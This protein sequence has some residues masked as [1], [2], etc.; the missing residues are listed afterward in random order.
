MNR[1]T[2]VAKAIVEGEFDGDGMNEEI[3]DSVA[4]A[5]PGVEKEG[6]RQ[7]ERFGGKF[8]EGF[9]SRLEKMAPRISKALG[10]RMDGR[11]A[12]ATMGDEAG[13]SFV[14]RMA[15]KVRGAGDRI[16][17][18][19]GDR[20]ASR[21][22][23]IRRGVDRALDDDFADRVGER[24]ASRFVATLSAEI[25][26][27]E[28]VIGGAMARLVSGNR[29]RGGAKGG[30]DIGRLFG[31]GS[32]N[33]A[34]NLMGKTIGGTVR[35]TQ[36]LT[37]GLS[38][39]FGTFTK[40]ASQAAQGANMLQKGMAGLQAVG[41][42]AGA[43]LGKV[44]P[45]I[46]ASGPAAAVAIAAVLVVMSA[47]VSVAGALV[48]IVV[49]LSA[50]IVSGLVGA[51]AVAG[52]AILAVVAAG[53]LLTAAFMSMTNAQRDAL[54][55]A[56][57]P[58]REVMTGIGQVMMQEMVP[59]FATWSTNLQRAVA[60]AAPAASVMG[61]AFAEAGNRLTASFSGPGFQA[62]ATAMTI[63]LPSIVTRLSSALGG[64]LN[65]TMGMFAA[66]MPLVQQFAGWLARVGADFSAWAN[67]AGGQNAI[68]DFANRAVESLQSLWG[69]VSE[70]FGFLGDLMF[71]AQAQAAGNSMF[72]SMREAFEG[73]RE[74][75]ASGDL[76][77]WFNDA[78]TL[79]GALWEVMQGLWE[80]F[81][82]LYNSG[83]LDA[84]A[85]S[86]GWI[87]GMMSDLAGPM[88]LMI[89][90][91]GWIQ[92]AFGSLNDT[93]G[94]IPAMIGG[95][96]SPI[97]AVIGQLQRAADMIIYLKN[98]ISGGDSG[99]ISGYSVGGNIADAVNGIVDGTQKQIKARQK[100]P[101][102]GGWTIP[103]LRDTGRNARSNTYERN[104][105]TMP[106]PKKGGSTA[107]PKYENPYKDWANSLIKMG[108]AL[109][110]EMAAAVKALRV[111]G[112]NGIRDAAKSVDHAALGKDLLT[113]VNDMRKGGADLIKDAQNAVNSAARTLASANSPAEAKA[114]LKE[115][116][117]AQ[118]DLKYAKK[119]AIALNKASSI[120][121][122]QRYANSKRT[123]DLLRGLKV[124]NATLA[125]YALARETLAVKI[126]EANEKLLDA[127]AMRDDYKKAISDAAKAFGDLTTAQGKMVDGVEQALTASDITTN[128][129]ERLNRIREFQKNM[130]LLL[131]SGLSNEAYKQI[132]DKGVDEGSAY[133]EAL[134][135][136]G[137]G[138]IG[139]VNSLVSQIGTASDQLGGEASKR[140]YQ[141]GVDAAQGLLDGL[142]KLDAQLERAAFTLGE[143]IAAQV[144]RALGIKSPSTVMIAAM[145]DV[146]DGGVIGL[147]NQ[148]TKLDRAAAELS[149]HLM[150]S[151]QAALDDAR[152]RASAAAA[153]GVSG[154]S[155]VNVGGVTII[156]PT[157]D[158][159]AVANEAINELV[160]RL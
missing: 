62:F 143:K 103:K 55:D 98:L 51:L 112:I 27:A 147:E 84:V 36:K 129:S 47:L 85:M 44:M 45:A 127:I 151:P 58:L 126:D 119:Q 83:V 113:N 87:A 95:I 73:F 101:K 80:I 8:G 121:D 32:R 93:L 13:D 128:L 145:D 16:S 57:V 104:G 77:S 34:L 142:T 68:V 115:L 88:S 2:R 37:S 150:P 10:D 46:A 14:D 158:P 124:H 53:G 107:K 72:D 42:R 102:G 65:G 39:V 56:F 134:L 54:K 23:Q 74:A 64:F 66:L 125:D 100:A 132:M 1:G 153:G 96:L 31:A 120:I 18:E 29:G 59:A 109:R 33:N 78:A 67:S 133:A 137:I 28:S 15:D 110:K 22:E 94:G 50:T 111:E 155:G 70:F 138:S 90:A 41:V 130:Q 105:G 116:K 38:S 7:G 11:A 40:G 123:G 97:T 71:S 82:A 69:F 140:L 52:G 159:K 122:K 141:A 149:K 136:G 106:D 92:N 114:A 108:P 9:R 91:I 17:K 60:L 160:G 79:G 26:D 63:Y 118:N 19:L 48:G 131:A 20:M 89:D 12:G 61:R 144:K 30:F 3:V 86:L 148:H 135:A 156:T 24:F 4:K 154:N 157:K 43:S 152:L 75:I 81:M 146:G 6:D 35:L 76:E 49:A 99:G 139:M 117:K 21:P 5:G 25:A